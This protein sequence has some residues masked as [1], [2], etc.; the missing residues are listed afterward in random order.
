M[1]RESCTY[2]ISLLNGKRRMGGAKAGW[3]GKGAWRQAGG[4]GITTG[5]GNPCS[6]TRPHWILSHGGQ[7]ISCSSVYIYVC[8]SILV[9]ISLLIS[10]HA[11][12]SLSYSHILYV[13]CVVSFLVCF[14]L[15]VSLL[16]YSEWRQWTATGERAHSSIWAGEH[17]QTHGAKQQPACYPGRIGGLFFCLKPSKGVGWIPNKTWVV[18]TPKI[19]GRGNFYLKTTFLF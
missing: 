5:A 1:P 18:W 14:V 12:L 6:V 9:T 19:F 4:H 13:C 2:S 16:S 7:W 10:C 11:Y 17:V 8:V 15:S 3:A